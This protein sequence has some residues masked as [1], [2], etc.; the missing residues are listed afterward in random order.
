MKIFKFL[1]EL[2]LHGIFVGLIVWSWWMVANWYVNHKPVLG[3]DFFNTVTYTRY[4]GENFVPFLAGWKYIWWSGQGIDSD[5]PAIHMHIMALFEKS[6]GAIPTVMWYM[7]GTTLAY[8]VFGYLTFWEMGRNRGLAVMLS[9]WGAMSISVYGALTWGG[10]LPF[11]ASQ[12][13][14][15]AATYFLARYLKRGETS[16]VMIAGVVVGIAAWG[17]AQ[18]AVVYILPLVTIAI[19][20][21]DGG[22]KRAIK[23]SLLFGIV[24]LLVAYPKLYARYV[25][26][27]HKLPFWVVEKTL[28]AVISQPKETGG[29]GV[30]PSLESINYGKDLAQWNKNNINL[31]REKNHPF[32]WPTLALTVGLYLLLIIFLPG[33]KQKLKVLGVL[34]G[35][36]YYVIFI[37]ALAKGVNIPFG[38][39][40]RVYWPVPFVVGW[41]VSAVWGEVAGI[42][43]KWFKL[44]LGV[45]VGGIGIGMGIWGVELTKKSFF[46][47]LD[48]KK[49]AYSE[50][51]SAWPILVNYL[52]S[53]QEREKLKK[54]VVPNWINPN[55]R[56]YRLYSADAQVNIW[57]NSMFDMPMQRGYIDPPIGNDR[58]G[59]FF[60]WEV[61]ATN[62][63]LVKIFKVPEQVAKN[64]GLFLADWFG[65][66]YLELG[67]ASASFSTLSSYLNTPEFIKRDEELFF[68]DNPKL[69][70]FYLG[71]GSIGVES[72]TVEVTSTGLGE[73]KVK[74]KDT[75]KLEF[76]GEDWQRY[77]VTGPGVV[78]PSG[79]VNP[80]M[81]VD[82]NESSK[83][84]FELG[85]KY[86]GLQSLHYYELNDEVVSPIIHPT[87]ARVLAVVGQD[88]YYESFFRTLGMENLNS[89]S[90]I[91]LKVNKHIEN[92]T[93]EELKRFDMVFMYGYQSKNGNWRAVERWVKEGGK[94]WVETG[95]D[96][97]QSD[98]AS[99]LPELFP[100][101]GT[102]KSDLGVKWDGQTNSQHKYL[103]GVNLTE[104]A[105]L[106]LDGKP[107]FISAG[108]G[109]KPGATVI[110]E[111]KGK[112]V[113]AEW[114][115]G[116]GQVVWSGLN[117][118]YHVLVHNNI[119][120]GKLI[121][122]ILSNEMA[123]TK[124]SIDRNYQVE[125]KNPQS[126][127]IELQ[128][129]AKGVILREQD[130]GWVVRNAGKRLA[131]YRTGPAYPG[132]I[133]VSTAGLAVPVKLSYW[134]WPVEAKMM[135]Y[136]VLSWIVVIWVVDY[137]VFGARLLGWWTK[138]VWGGVK[139]FVGKWWEK[140]DV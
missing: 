78:G 125:W 53:N 72:N 100:I 52:T 120:E 29:A 124:T 122:N 37:F 95:G 129:P 24:F 7:M 2:A 34:M 8:L 83:A 126:I 127:Q 13:F 108:M 39:W 65:I 3:V 97:P 25:P 69:I 113:M 64:N 26:D 48:D 67:H 49:L 114:K 32:L 118:P 109:L 44:G 68:V 12:V 47:K 101:G 41:I 102:K 77:E 110:L 116:Q 51:S 30:A 56:M 38:G 31:V 99:G 28:G 71:K 20:A 103:D 112:P 63:Q 94:V 104:L 121:A 79:G 58:K 54:M 134:I 61:A 33:R 22:I 23:S 86:L 40:Y 6:F 130:Y 66:K 5:Y 45:V 128:S 80:G 74:G 85:F 10:S 59:G 14:L 140:E 21:L 138:P 84:A 36:I 90:V 137:S 132:Y 87:N 55:D 16:G 75:D 136:H 131:T 111:Q 105:D 76:E 81:V 50:N 82:V 60:W 123:L 93:Y 15:P 107:W 98:T 88:N 1:G 43:S 115:V 119:F 46:A 70:N 4:L 139:K 17:H 73:F 11:F 91:P 133:Y 19:F 18:T 35:G 62:D 89:K 117:I 96:T 57:W 92:I 9:L 27:L 135:V 106:T 42:G